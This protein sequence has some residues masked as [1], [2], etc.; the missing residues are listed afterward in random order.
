VLILLPSFSKL[1][2]ALSYEINKDFIAKTLC[3]NRAHPAL[4]C[5]GKCHL[6]KE[7]RQEERRNNAPSNL[8][9]DFELLL[10]VEDN[11]VV[12]PFCELPN[13]QH[14]SFYI[15]KPYSAPLAGIYHPPKA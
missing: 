7:M 8:L 9:K 6:K 13:L 1:T 4:H 14:L 15:L 12:T 2:V 10:F 5:N 11:A 3:E